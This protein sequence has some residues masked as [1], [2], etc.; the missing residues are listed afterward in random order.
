MKAIEAL[1]KWIARESGVVWPPY[2]ADLRP[3]KVA[4]IAAQHRLLGFGETY[5]DNPANS[6]AQLDAI[7]AALGEKIREA[8]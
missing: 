2:S 5:C 7:I 8:K 4:V 3:L 1:K 6:A